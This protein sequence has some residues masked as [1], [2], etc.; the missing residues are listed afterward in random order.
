[1]V[2][3]QGQYAVR[4]DGTLYVCKG[5][6]LEEVE[7]LTN[8]RGNRLFVSDL[9]GAISRAMTI[10]APYKY[11]EVMVKKHLQE[12]GEF[13]EPVTVIT[14]WKKKKDANA[15]DIFF[16]ALA[17]RLYYQYIDQI[18]AHDDSILLFPVYSVLYGV[19]KRMRLGGADFSAVIFQHDR[20]ADLI[21]GSGKR[22]FYANR[23]VAFDESEDQLSSLW[24]M[25]ISDIEQTEKEFRIKVKKIL[26]L[27]WINSH[28]GPNLPDDID[29]ELSYMEEEALFL[30]GESF[31]VSFLNALRMQ[32]ASDS[33]SGSLE[34]ASYYFQKSLPCLNIIFFLF[35]LTFITGCLWCNHKA[36]LIETDIK[37][38]HARISVQAGGD[39]ILDIPSYKDHFAFIKELEQYRKSPSFKQLINDLSSSVPE[40]M[41]ADIVKADYTGNE[42]NV[43]VFARIKAPFDTAYKSCQRFSG[44]MLRK[45]Y[46]LEK[47]E[48][49]TAIQ[50]SRFLVRFKKG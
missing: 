37:N 10:E 9:D 48:F 44:A 34:K 13:D 7:D 28:A 6:K 12:A 8:T 16:T 17:T 39:D 46:T 32:P 18:K 45:G 11:A 42:L 33:V 43:E 49:N 35:I 38:N 19:L 2:N 5:D 26:M 30:N 15:T 41:L 27:N 3:N 50:E 29:H 21:I 36:G 31:S 1:M 24:D 20:Y 14:H 25:V 40:G 4:M 22:I 23:C 47:S